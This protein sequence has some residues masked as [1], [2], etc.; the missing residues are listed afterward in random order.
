MVAPQDIFSDVVLDMDYARDVADEINAQVK[1]DIGKMVKL[2][3][4]PL[5]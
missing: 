3:D 4:N 5:G 1:G 2:W